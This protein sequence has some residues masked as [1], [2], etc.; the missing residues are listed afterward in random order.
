MLPEA[1]IL[2]PL[3]IKGTLVVTII[4]LFGGALFLYLTSPLDQEKK[5]IHMNKMVDGFLYLMIFIIVAKIILNMP[6]FFEDPVAVL[7]YP[8]NSTALY[9]ALAMTIGVMVVSKQKK[10]ML[11]GDFIDSLARFIVGSQFI[12]LFFTLILTTYK[13]S[14][15]Q[16]GF[17]FITL[18]ALLF[19]S[20]AS[21]KPL[22]GLLILYGVGLFS[23]SFIDFVPF[24]GFYVHGLFYLTFSLLGSLFI[25]LPQKKQESR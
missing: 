25:F 6:L 12:Q 18:L 15:Y 16:L 17:L 2:G 14:V 10:V 24:F 23:L 9:L 7:A 22:F 11:S 4:G 21:Q 3:I 5:K 1:I 19:I 20:P 8:S 13:V